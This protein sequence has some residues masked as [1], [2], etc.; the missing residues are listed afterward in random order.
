[1]RKSN[2]FIITLL[3]F[4]LALTPILY[5]ESDKPLN[6]VFDQFICIEDNQNGY[7]FDTGGMFNYY[8]VYVNG[9]LVISNVT[10]KSFGLT[11][12]DEH[13]TLEVV[14]GFL[15]CEY[16]SVWLMIRN[17]DESITLLRMSTIGVD[18]TSN[19]IL[20]FIWAFWM[21]TTLLIIYKMDDFNSWNEHR[22]LFKK[23]KEDKE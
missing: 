23:G 9:E 14:S 18:R 15:G 3:V 11:N 12:L 13:S 17:Y 2:I 8:E 16:R 6:V 22:I 21:A 1:M 4:V 10:T 5:I 7:I 19:F 20:A